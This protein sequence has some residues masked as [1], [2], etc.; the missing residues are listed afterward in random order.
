[1]NRKGFNQKFSICS[2][3]IC[4]SFTSTDLPIQSVDGAVRQLLGQS[5]V[6]SARV[7]FA[8]LRISHLLVFL[9]A[10]TEIGS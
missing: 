2:T 8:A 7:L 3:Q 10:G 4:N 9:S 6:L 5:V 1:M